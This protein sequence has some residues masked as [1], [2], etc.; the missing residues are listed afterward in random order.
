MNANL[1]NVNPA[2]IMTRLYQLKAE[3]DGKNITVIA[4]AE[5]REPPHA[6]AAAMPEQRQA[7]A[8]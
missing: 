2:T 3:Q 7:V 5:R 1:I 4:H 8:G 6:H